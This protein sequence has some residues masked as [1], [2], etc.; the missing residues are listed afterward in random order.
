M[1]RAAIADYIRAKAE[2]LRH[3]HDWQK[4]DSMEVWEDNQPRLPSDLPVKVVQVYCC[5]GCGEFRKVTLP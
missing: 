5:R 1:I 4:K 2:K 3:R